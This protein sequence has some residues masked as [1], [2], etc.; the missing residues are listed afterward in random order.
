MGQTHLPR[1][2]AAAAADEAGVWDG[3]VGRAERTAVEESLTGMEAAEPSP[4]GGLRRSIFQKVMRRASVKLKEAFCTRQELRSM[5]E[6]HGH[7]GCDAA[8]GAIVLI[9]GVLAIYFR[10]RDWL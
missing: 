1:T 4:V 10:R 9:G 8:L 3:V 2:R 7:Y 5:P 6:L